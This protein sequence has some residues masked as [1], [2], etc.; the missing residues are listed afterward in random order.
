MEK[1]NGNVAPLEVLLAQTDSTYAAGWLRKSNFEDANIQPLQLVITQE[2]ATLVMD[3]GFG[4]YSQW[5][6]G[7]QNNMADLLSRDTDLP[8]DTLTPC[9]L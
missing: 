9:L 2:M 5:F 6:P 8:P 1:E 4:L 3:G 7:D